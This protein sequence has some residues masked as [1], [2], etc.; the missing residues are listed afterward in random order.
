MFQKEW[1]N[2]MNT[3]VAPEIDRQLGGEQVQIRPMK[4]VP[5]KQSVPDTDYEPLDVCAIFDWPVQMALTRDNT[6]VQSREPEIRL[7]YYQ[8]PD[9]YPIKSGYYLYVYRTQALFEINAVEQSGVD[10]WC[11]RLTQLGRAANR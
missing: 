8:V 10:H 7:G 1:R 5:N 9:G 2:M 11:L 4:R 6:P 3:D